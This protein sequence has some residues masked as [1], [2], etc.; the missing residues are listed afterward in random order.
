MRKN[1]PKQRRGS[2]GLERDEVLKEPASR[3]VIRL[4]NHQGKA[5][6]RRFGQGF[7]CRPKAQKRAGPSLQGMGPLHGAEC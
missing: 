1:R 5:F 7:T 6:V 3:H 2:A 4:I